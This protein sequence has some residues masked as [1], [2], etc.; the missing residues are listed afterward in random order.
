MDK[1][2]LTSTNHHNTMRS[3][4]IDSEYFASRWRRNLPILLRGVK[5]GRVPS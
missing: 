5:I 2:D 4:S 1:A 3:S